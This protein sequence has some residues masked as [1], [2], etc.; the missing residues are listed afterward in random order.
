MQ[1]TRNIVDLA[2]IENDLS[3]VDQKVWPDIAIREAEFLSGQKR[4]DNL[5]NR[6]A[7]TVGL[8]DKGV[9]L[10]I[11]D[12][13]EWLKAAIHRVFNASWQ[14]CKVHWMRNV[15][16]YVSKLQQS[17]VPAALRQAFS[18]TAPQPAMPCAMSPIS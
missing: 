4:D 7:E 8:N 12:A 9:K 16:S 2:R 6:T 18:P 13:H 17:M 3:P 5:P 14:R 10:V 1:I 11:S 15:P